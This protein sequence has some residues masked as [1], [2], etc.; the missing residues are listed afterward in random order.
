MER[1]VIKKKMHL[2]PLRRELHVDSI[3]EWEPT[4]EAL[5]IDGYRIDRMPGVEPSEGMRQLKVLADRDP[6][7]PP[8][9]PLE[10]LED[11]P[12]LQKSDSR[13]TSTLC[14]LPVLGCIS[15]AKAYLEGKLNIPS[16]LGP[17]S[18][19]QLEFLEMFEDLFPKLAGLPELESRADQD[20]KVINA[21]LSERGFDI[22]LPP[23]GGDT[24]NVASILDVLVRWLHTG[25]K[26]AIQGREEEY[27]GIRLEEGVTIAHMAAIHPHPVVR[28]ATKEGDTVC[29]SMVDGVPDG[30][31]GLFLKV[32]DL[33]KVKAT[34]HNFKGVSF[35]MVDLDQRPDI[36]WLNGLEV[37][38][39]YRIGCAMQQTKFRMNEKGARVESAAAA[40][41]YR[42]VA[43]Q[44]QPHI[45]DRPFLLWIKRDG[46]EFP[47]FAALLCEDVW[48]EPKSL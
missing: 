38:S 12:D 6:E 14:V 31:T 48:K 2:G 9:E 4:T 19:E 15:A 33:E 5:M 24:F 40:Q 34:S 11:Q 35:P 3:I 8:I 1:Y 16:E 26:T 25:K 17:C 7:N 10:S 44:K 23:A 43:P 37:G 32:A 20:Y 18:D 22:Q 21:W 47:L 46:F 36:S 30:I 45:I 27:V 28:V 41:L 13:G 29:M 42:S 39:G